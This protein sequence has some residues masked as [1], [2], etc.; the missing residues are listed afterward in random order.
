MSRRPAGLAA[1]AAA[2]SLAALTGCS[3]GDDDGTPT[4]PASTTPASTAP[5]AVPGTGPGV[6]RPTATLSP[7][8]ASPQTPAPSSGL[9]VP[10]PS[11]QQ[12]T[13]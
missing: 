8:S 4:A 7:G 10:I 2:L 5:S 6:P 3:G 13:R 9:P 1:V 12:T 11:D